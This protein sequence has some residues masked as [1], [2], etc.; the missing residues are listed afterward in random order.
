MTGVYGGEVLIGFGA[1][2]TRKD[3]TGSRSLG[4]PYTN[5]T[6]FPMEVN[7]WAQNPAGSAGTLSLSIDGVIVSS[8]Q[9]YG[10]GVTVTKVNVCAIVMPGETYTVTGQVPSKWTECSV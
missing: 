7:V 3:V 10:S 1:G 4:T 6:S 2:Q 8:N 9:N 5:N